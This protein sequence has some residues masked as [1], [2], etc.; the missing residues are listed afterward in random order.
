MTKGKKKPNALKH[1]AYSGPTQLFMWGEAPADYD[2]L[3]NGLYAEYTP[4]GPTEVHWVETLADLLWRRRRVDRYDW[5][6]TLRRLREVAGRDLFS[7]SVEKIRSFALDF[8]KART[9]A[10]VD[11]IIGKVSSTIDFDF[12]ILV[13]LAWP[14]VPDAAPETWGPQIAKGVLCSELPERYDDGELFVQGLDLNFMD[15]Q[16][17]RIEHLD[18]MIDKTV[19]RL[20]QTKAMKQMHQGLEGLEP[21]RGSSSV[22][23]LGSKQNADQERSL[24]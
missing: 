5:V 12:S 10:E 18:A 7:R 13:S 9:V 17:S 19:K 3:R 14:L 4:N 11:L 24:Q 1:G 2:A 21:K 15:E 6:L 23:R 8:Y 22:A 20:M 16:L